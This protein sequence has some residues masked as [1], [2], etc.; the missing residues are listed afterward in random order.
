MHG[1]L[2]VVAGGWSVSGIFRYQSGFPLPLSMSNTLGI[3]NQRMRPDVVTG[4]SRA[5][6]IGNGDFSP[7]AD[8]HI[9]LAAF[10][11]PAPY[12]FGTSAPTYQDPRTFP[13]LNEDFS[14]IKQTR[15]SEA[16]QLEIY[17]QIFNAFNRH[18]FH[19]FD[20]N[21]SSSGFGLAKGV[22]LPRFMQ[23]GMRL[24]F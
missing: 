1:P 9:N 5:T 14:V 23:L 11:A 4:Q 20:S 6:A 24:R 3:F 16:V 13:V 18:R 15:I 19:T 2:G 17:G 22:S 10:T 8:R 12:R 7:S 21:F